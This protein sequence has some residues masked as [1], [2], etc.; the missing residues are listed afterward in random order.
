VLLAIAC[1]LLATPAHA[2]TVA[3]SEQV[4][5][6]LGIEVEAATRR[7]DAGTG[8]V[9]LRVAFS[10]D[11]EW[12]IKSPLPG[13][14]HRALVQ[15]G[16]RVSAG[17]PLAVVR[18]P[19]FVSLQRDYL[20]A[21]AEL[22]MAESARTRDSRLREAG[23]IADRRWQE[24]EYR[25][26]T[27]EA[28]HAALRGQLILAGLAEQDLRQLAEEAAISP[29]LVLR[30]PADAIVLD[31]PAPLGS[32]LDGMEILVRL[33]EPDKLVLNGIITRAAADRLRE[34]TRLRLN[35][36]DTGAVVVFVSSV[37]DTESQTV[38]VR[39]VPD[40]AAGL[41]PG[42]LSEWSV[43]AGEPALLLPSSAV[44]RLDDRDV[45]YVAV[46]GGFE[47]RPVA[48]RG[49]ASG[50]WVVLDGLQDGERV[51]VRGTA[52]LKGASLGLG[53]GDDG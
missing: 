41:A 25:Y 8:S 30:A 1:C 22:Q 15:Q 10:P 32:Q 49:T 9:T 24:T 43:L 47:P 28:E 4:Q 13:L 5:Q 2:A 31:R 29:D 23:S 6:A 26:R 33:G 39:A 46:P 11:A 40:S 37:L 17:E 20:Q 3:I 53:G 51:A 36:G 14:L 50:A 42:Q 27:A 16:D 48:V 45:V 34:G 52:V 7:E 44:V 12:V 38:D 35:G 19:E 18:S 21:R